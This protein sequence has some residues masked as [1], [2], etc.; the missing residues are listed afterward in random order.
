MIAI[1]AIAKWLSKSEMRSY[2]SQLDRLTL[3]PAKDAVESVGQLIGSGA[4]RAKGATG[5]ELA[6]GCAFRL[7]SLNQEFVAKFC[8]VR[9][10]DF[11]FFAPT[12]R[13]RI[14]NGDYVV[15]G[16][17]NDCSTTF[18]LQE[19]NDTVFVS[20]EEDV[21]VD[22]EMKFP[23]IWHAILFEASPVPSR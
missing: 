19:G 1:A 20:D 15:V 23:S 17:A 11:I 8:E 2:R 3:L 7:G 21:E 12:R 5:E 6:A 4:L 18:L 9:G 10:K 22:S 13:K 14:G 16:S